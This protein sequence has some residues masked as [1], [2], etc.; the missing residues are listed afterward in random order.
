L[1]VGV[2][3]ETIVENGVLSGKFRHFVCRCPRS[4]EG[5]LHD[6]DCIDIGVR[7][8]CALPYSAELPFVNASH[9]NGFV[10]RLVIVFIFCMTCHDDLR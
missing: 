1:F 9:E 5:A 10:V 3:H 8:T 4:R 2:G 7:V 6:A